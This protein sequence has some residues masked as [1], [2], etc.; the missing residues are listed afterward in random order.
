[1]DSVLVV[2][3]GGS[4]DDNDNNNDDD[5]DDDDDNNDNDNKDATLPTVCSIPCNDG[6]HS[7]KGKGFR[8]WFGI[9]LHG[10]K[11]FCAPLN[12]SS[13]LVVNGDKE[14]LCC[15]PCSDD[16]TNANFKWMG[17]VALPCNGNNKNGNTVPPSTLTQF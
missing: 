2:D 16:K 5:D 3:L 14:T 17:I 12:K 10:D 11:L 7:N 8:K 4:T 9:T 6:Q 13:F 1:M 15:L